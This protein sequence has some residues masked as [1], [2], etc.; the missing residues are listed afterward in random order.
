MRITIIVKTCFNAKH[1]WREA[2]EEVSFLRIAHD[3]TFFVEA[4]I[5]GSGL[6]RQLEFFM[7]KRVI[8]K[9]LDSFRGGTFEYSCEYFAEAILEHLKLK[10]GERSYTVT[11]SEDGVNAGRV[12]Y[13]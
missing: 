8:D 3:H 13:E 4:E 5:S 6:N 10:Y 1:F 11:V 12:Y 7:V 9:F 2:P